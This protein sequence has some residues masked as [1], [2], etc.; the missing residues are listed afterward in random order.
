MK[1]FEVA[2]RRRLHPMRVYWI[3]I[4]LLLLISLAVQAQEIYV[5]LEQPGILSQ[6]FDVHRPVIYNVTLY[7]N[8]SY[9][10]IYDVGL[11]IKP[12][13]N[14]SLTEIF[15]ETLTLHP[16]ESQSLR[17]EVNFSSPEIISPDLREWTVNGTGKWVDSSYLF[18]VVPRVG[19]GAG[20]VTRSIQ[21]IHTPELVKPKITA[22]KPEFK[23]GL[24]STYEYMVTVNGNIAAEVC[25]E[26]APSRGGPW[27]PVGCQNYTTLGKAQSLEWSGISLSPLVRSYYR[28]TLPEPTQAF[29]GPMRNFREID[30]HA[31]KAPNSVRTSVE[32][33]ATYLTSPAKD[34]VEKARAIF[35]WM[36]K[37]IAYDTSAYF[38]KNYG[39]I[40]AKSVLKSGKS[41]CA[42]YSDLF[43]ALASASGLD[44]VTI[45]GYAKGYGYK[46]G[47]HFTET[48]HAWNAVK[49]NGSWYLLDSTWGAGYMDGHSFVRKFQPFYFLTPPEDLIYTHLP[50]EDR[51][52]LLER[53]ITLEDFEKLPKHDDEFFEENPEFTDI[54]F[55][56]ISN[57]A[58]LDI[59]LR[60]YDEGGRSSNYCRF[61]PTSAS[62]ISLFPA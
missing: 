44:V 18:Q 46:G 12:T 21:S 54:R 1:E 43:E 16:G 38:S 11:I 62:W 24:N 39:D 49:L 3:L 15:N 13:N 9:T 17:L 34:D 10:L 2:N 14:S 50:T 31:I 25:L 27:T 47:S 32:S 60:C 19:I 36:A 33:L 28:F 41:I 45:D 61:Y 7:E 8:K 55:M 51:W 59:I 52:Q 29:R 53:N 40:N 23:D 37:N 58:K 56:P 22:M 4:P 48:N 20:T 6:P 57:S 35:R 42:G 26:V 5:S 30:D